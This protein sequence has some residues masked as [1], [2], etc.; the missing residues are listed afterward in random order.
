TGILALLIATFGGLFLAA[1]ALDPARLAFRRQQAFIADAAHELRTPLTLL[2]A[3]AD[4]LLR[5][6]NRLPEE[7]AALVADIA[8]EAAHMSTLT[9]T[10]LDMARLDAGRSHLERDVVDLVAVVRE[11]V[12]RTDAY[13]CAADVTL[14][15]GHSGNVLTLGDQTLLTQAILILIDNAIKYN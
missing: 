1:R 2:R 7:D 9:T 6:R 12:Q 8:A 4:V 13:A 11:T 14:D 3:D 10:M 5:S 15:Y